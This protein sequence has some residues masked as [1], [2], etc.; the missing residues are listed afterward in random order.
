VA[1]EVEVG[2]AAYMADRSRL[3]VRH[4]FKCRRDSMVAYREA[5]RAVGERGLNQQT[6]TLAVGIMPPRRMY[7]S[8]SSLKQKLET[9][10][11]KFCEAWRWRPVIES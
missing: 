4:A 8:A 5:V 11:V 10:C 2:V 3:T 7:P 9:Y 6:A 1:L